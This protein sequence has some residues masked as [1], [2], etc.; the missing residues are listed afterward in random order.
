MYT[1][2]IT[3]KP[4]II[5]SIPS[6]TGWSFDENSNMLTR[7]WDKNPS[8]KDKNS[9]IKALVSHLRDQIINFENLKI[10]SIISKISDDKLLSSLK[11]QFKYAMKS[12]SIE[13]ES[14]KPNSN[15]KN[16]EPVITEVNALINNVN[17]NVN[18]S[19]LPSDAL[20]SVILGIQS[21]ENLTFWP[22]SSANLPDTTISTAF[23]SIVVAA[24]TNSELANTLQTAIKALQSNTPIVIGYKNKQGQG[25][26]ISFTLSNG[27]FTEEQLN[28]ILNLYNEAVKQGLALTTTSAGIPPL[29]LESGNAIENTLAL[30]KPAFSD[31]LKRSAMEIMAQL[32]LTLRQW[33]TISRNEDY[34]NDTF[35]PVNAPTKTVQDE[36]P[37]YKDDFEDEEIPEED[38]ITT[39][40]KIDAENNELSEKFNNLQLLLNKL[41]NPKEQQHQKNYDSLFTRYENL[42]AT[43]ASGQKTTFTNDL[44]L[45]KNDIANFENRV[46]NALIQEAPGLINLTPERINA[47]NN[48]KT[49]KNSTSSTNEAILIATNKPINIQAPTPAEVLSTD[50]KRVQAEIAALNALPNVKDKEPAINTLLTSLDEL[51]KRAT[52]LNNG[53]LGLLI[54]KEKKEVT[55]L[56]MNALLLT[57]QDLIEIGVALGNNT[58][59]KSLLIDDLKPSSNGKKDSERVKAITTMDTTIATNNK[60]LIEGGN[61]LLTTLTEKIKSNKKEAK[62]AERTKNQILE[63]SENNTTT[64]P[65]MTDIF[66]NTTKTNKSESENEEVKKL[67]EQLVEKDKILEENNKQLKEL[68][69]QVEGLEEPVKNLDR[70]LNEANN[71]LN[72][73]ETETVTTLGKLSKAEQDLLDF[74]NKT[75][76]LQTTITTKDMEYTQT[77]NKLSSEVTDKTGQQKND[78]ETALAKLKS[79]HTNEIDRLNE[80]IKTLK[81][82][83][84]EFQTELNTQSTTLKTSQKT[85]EELTDEVNGFKQENQALLLRI[86]LLTGLGAQQ[87]IALQQRAREHQA[88]II[89]MTTSLEDVNSKLTSASGTIKT[90][91]NENSILLAET[92]TMSLEIKQYKEKT[93]ELEEKITIKNQKITELQTEL[94][95]TKSDLANKPTPFQLDLALATIDRLMKKIQT[96]E[97]AP[98]SQNTNEQVLRTSSESL[99]KSEQIIERNTTK[100][101]KMPNNSANRLHLITERRSENANHET[102]IHTN[103]SKWITIKSNSASPT[104][105]LQNDERVRVSL[106]SKPSNSFQMASHNLSEKTSTK[107][108]STFA[109]DVEARINKDL[110]KE[111]KDNGYTCKCKQEGDKYIVNHSYTNNKK[112]VIDAPPI[113]IEPS[114]GKVTSAIP[115]MNDKL[116]MTI[117]AKA[118]V[119]SFI[120]MEI[121]RG[122]KVTEL[123]KPIIECPAEMQQELDEA[124]ISAIFEIK[125]NKTLTPL[126]NSSKKN[127]PNNDNDNN[128][129]TITLG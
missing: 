39:V 111:I 87:K 64:R 12:S 116:A 54:A 18:I 90:L 6:Y 44:T 81:S 75:Q 77:L 78:Y 93:N 46:N 126:S 123:I 38:S 114:G 89:E 32:I 28:H 19:R 128:E 108:S 8:S 22:T 117:A 95:Q 122:I 129:I 52:A 37:I 2:K 25:N 91:S 5:S 33:P 35:E 49:I 101:I 23:N 65:K 13:L 15:T 85:V 11:S 61:L 118:A 103:D 99:N 71:K 107:V 79:S 109:A 60:T 24:Q 14:L 47:L 7:K 34:A 74:K 88:K 51:K 42:I 58:T 86:E 29:H 53:G 92:L 55:K 106:K 3:L 9:A 94:N 98:I 62:D 1:I 10:D 82:Q 43:Y 76:E 110:W 59:I 20:A 72:F 4:K 17:N 113:T 63:Q 124:W 80:Q 127:E 48:S 57:N 105:D 21:Q 73:N 120:E 97:T 36:N 45:L 66:A 41:K 121:S 26:A 119:A 100:H 102:N 125:E 84:K 96:L 67:R 31:E 30:I 40:R 104:Q 56:Y 50:L 112:N 70:S 27:I 115:D 69:N 83:E 16:N 68:K